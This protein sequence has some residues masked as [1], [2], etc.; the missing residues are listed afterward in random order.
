MLII[1]LGAEHQLRARLA[2]VEFDNRIVPDH[3][4]S[5]LIASKDA[6]EKLQRII[7][8]EKARQVLYSGI[9]LKY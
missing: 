9:F 3:G 1:S 8:M 7:N 2:M 5:D 6:V 4:L